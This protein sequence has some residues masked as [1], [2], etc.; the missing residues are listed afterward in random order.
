M[1]FDFVEFAIGVMAIAASITFL[2]VAYRVAI[3]G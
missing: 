1:R 2:C 3:G